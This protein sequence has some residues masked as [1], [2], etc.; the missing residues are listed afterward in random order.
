MYQWFL[1][2]GSSQRKKVCRNTVFKRTTESFRFWQIKL[3][4]KGFVISSALHSR[5][6]QEISTENRVL[7][8]SVDLCRIKAADF[9]L[10]NSQSDLHSVQSFK[11][12][13][14]TAFSFLFLSLVCLTM[15]AGSE[16]A[17]QAVTLTLRIIH[18]DSHQGLDF[19]KKK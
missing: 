16:E 9:R 3:P 15:N 2:V 18:G 17:V 11:H 4:W 12:I 8:F 19:K 13:L 10:T 5:G 7:P 1:T 14:S 6:N